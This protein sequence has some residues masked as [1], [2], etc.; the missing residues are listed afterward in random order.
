MLTSHGCVFHLYPCM[1][2][3]SN[4]ATRRDEFG[5]TIGHLETKRIQSGH[6]ECMLA[7]SQ[8]HRRRIERYM[9]APR[10]GKIMENSDLDAQ[11]TAIRRRDFI[12]LGASAGVM[13]ALDPL[14]AS[15]QSA[16][17]RPVSIDLHTHWVPEAYERALAQLKRP[18]PASTDPL[19][20]DL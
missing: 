12:K 20:F 16:T 2:G 4:R 17:G 1:P 14:G 8:L 3:K 13:L 11:A 7:P 9:I 18:T 10:E 5:R 6:S 19:D 15:A